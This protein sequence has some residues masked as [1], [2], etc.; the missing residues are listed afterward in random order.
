[1]SGSK[2]EQSRRQKKVNIA[3]SETVQEFMHVLWTFGAAKPLSENFRIGWDRSFAIEM[4]DVTQD[5]TIRG[6]VACV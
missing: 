6:R 3:Q 5:D 1:M 2:T 4:G